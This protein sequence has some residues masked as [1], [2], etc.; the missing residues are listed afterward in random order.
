MQIANSFD[1]TTC[2]LKVY[3]SKRK[4]CRY[5][6]HKCTSIFSHSATENPNPEKKKQNLGG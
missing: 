4:K 3:F 1:Y 6:L 2:C 5:N